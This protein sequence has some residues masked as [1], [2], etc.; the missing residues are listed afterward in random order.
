MLGKIALPFVA[1]RHVGRDASSVESRRRVG[2]LKDGLHLRRVD[3][4][5]LD[6][7][8]LEEEAADGGRFEFS[9]VTLLVGCWLSMMP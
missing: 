9:A 5:F 7:V 6:S 8:V 3:R 1:A 2:Q 4:L